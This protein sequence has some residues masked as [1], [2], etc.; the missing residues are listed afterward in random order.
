MKIKKSKETLEF[1]KILE[2]HYP[3][4]LNAPRRIHIWDE[5]LLDCQKHGFFQNRNSKFLYQTRWPAL[6]RT[7]LSK[8]KNKKPLSEKDK[9]V[10]SICRTISPDF[11]KEVVEESSEKVADGNDK[12]Y[13][14][15]EDGMNIFDG[16]FDTLDPMDDF[17]KDD[18][19]IKDIVEC[20]VSVVSDCPD[21]EVVES[22][23]E[24]C[25]D[26]APAAYVQEIPPSTA[27]QEN[28]AEPTAVQNIQTSSE[29]SN[30]S[31]PT[32]LEYPPLP[33]SAPS[34]PGHYPHFPPS[35]TYP[36]PPS[37]LFYSTDI[38]KAQVEALKA[39]TAN[40]RWS[41]YKIQ[42]EIETLKKTNTSNI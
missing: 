33:P 16:D 12:Y 35:L 5:I 4:M 6:T 11:C 41:T 13:T 19:V 3:R 36:P 32:A 10:I 7:T 9:L 14:D 27:E 39:Y 40:C 21:V 23:I 17:N 28:N 15:D 31:S 18:I 37:P 20:M 30:V 1:L 8:W 38:E 42:M 26:D 34:F 29:S 24:R 22:A 25:D 2:K